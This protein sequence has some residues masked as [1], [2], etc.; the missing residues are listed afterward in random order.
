MFSLTVPHVRKTEAGCVTVSDV[1]HG[2]TA[3][4]KKKKKEKQRAPGI[5]REYEVAKLE[6]S[7][8]GRSGSDSFHLLPSR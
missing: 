1:R 3:R 5:G 4:Q 7:D 2:M 6:R 8:G